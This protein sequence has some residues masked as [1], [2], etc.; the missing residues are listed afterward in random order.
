[1]AETELR[2]GAS[3]RVHRFLHRTPTQAVRP[4]QHARLKVLLPAVL[5]ML[6][7]VLLAGC[8]GKSGRELAVREWS[9]WSLPPDGARLPAPRRVVPGLGGEMLVLDDVG[10]VLVY[11]ASGELKR[12]W[13]MPDSTIGRP[14]G[15][16]VLRDG[17][18]FVCDT[19]YQR[20]VVFD[21]AG[22]VLYMFGSEGKGPGQF[23]YPVAITADDEDNLYICE[24]GGNDR[25]QMFRPDGTYLSGFGGFGTGP[26][27]FQRPS[28]IVWRDGRLYVADAINN[29]VLVFEDAK[30]V[31][32]LGGTEGAPTLRF[33]Y[34]IAP[35]P[36]GGLLVVE[37][38]AGRVTWLTADG[39]LAGR[40]CAP[41][42][43][44][45]NLRT[46]WSLS[47]SASGEVWVADTGNRRLV[48]MKL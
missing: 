43:G 1:V 31:G 48:R 44:Q 45:G 33:P 32:I 47:V 21:Q 7:A 27:E 20:I 36:D 14:E 35:A 8:G 41:G 2:H 4:G 11:D 23:I 15:A 19:H 3:G 40:A 17:R 25:V 42:S 30:F 13:R 38:Q 12:Q 26:G 37:Y 24:Y 6:A 28:G 29:R 5:F 34:D 39:K 22:T 10:R 9:A 46:P 16:C 18:I